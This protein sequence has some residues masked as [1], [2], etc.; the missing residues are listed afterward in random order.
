MPRKTH[1]AYSAEATED[2]RFRMSIY[3]PKEMREF[4]EL[5][6]KRLSEERGERTLPADIVRALIAAYYE[7]RTI[8]E[9]LVTP[10]D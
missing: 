5:E 8:A 7:K 3:V 4:L 1:K 2:I 6:A 9:L 10:D